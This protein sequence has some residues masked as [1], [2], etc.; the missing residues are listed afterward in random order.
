[1]PIPTHPELH[2]EPF[3]HLAGLTHDDA[4]FSWGGFWFRPPDDPDGHWT[5]VE[6]PA[7]ADIEEIERRDTIGARS[8]PYGAARVEVRSLETGELAGAATV[9]DVN[10]AW[11]RGL[12][13]RTRYRYRVLVDGDEWAAGPTR[14]CEVDEGGFRLVDRGRRYDNTFRTFPAVR[15]RAPVS[16]AV[17]GDYGIGILASEGRGGVQHRLATAL[18]RAVEHHDVELVVT[19]GDNVYLGD[20]DTAAGTGRH[21]DDWYFSFYEPYRHVINRVPVYPS[22]GNHDTDDT[23]HSDDRD[24]LADN[25]FTDVR[26]AEGAEVGR[27][28]VDPGLNYRFDVGADVELIAIDTTLASDDD[29]HDQFFQIP[30]HR[31]FLEDIFRDEGHTEGEPFPRWRIP[32][33]HHPAFCAGPHHPNTEP[34]VEELVPLFERSGVRLVLAG[35]EHNFQL[36]RHHGITYVVTGAGGKVRD[37]RPEGFEAAHTE[38][39]AAEGHFLLVEIDGDRCTL[40]PVT[41]ISDEG[42]IQRLVVHR[43]DGTEHPT[44]IVL[45]SDLG[46]GAQSSTT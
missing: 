5:I 31:S 43:P 2:F 6:D 7:F 11:V 24:Q 41:D 45:H 18:E 21:D 35:H 26:F 29:E 30:R 13:P 14:A 33:S 22:V 19:T 40:T 4:L 16:F 9:D 37:G 10:H 17:L 39:W 25:M 27:A 28:S 44:P 42:T 1:M 3:L 20:E 34:M 15:D 32:F 36:S 38:G 8:K 23:E 46:P 12:E